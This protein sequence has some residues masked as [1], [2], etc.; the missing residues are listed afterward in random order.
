MKTVIQ[1][2]G[3][4]A[5]TALGTVVI[6]C[7]TP[8]GDASPNP[9]RRAGNKEIFR[10]SAVAKEAKITAP[11][12]LSFTAAPSAPSATSAAPVVLTLT[13]RALTDIPSGVARVVLPSGVTLISGQ[14]EVEFG[15]LPKGAERQ[16]TLT[17]DAPASGQS[18]IFAGVDC[19]IS[20]GIQLHKEAQPLLV[21]RQTN[22]PN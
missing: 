11:V 22:S 18:Q 5:L 6:G 8:Q 13:V 4:V 1:T 10:S 12:Q 9:P 17:V 14:P 21:G 2:L 20:S 19:H 7:S 16:F 15:A 3:L